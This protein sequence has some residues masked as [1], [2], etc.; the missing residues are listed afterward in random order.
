MRAVVSRGGRPDLAPRSL[1]LVAAPTL[2]IVGEL[3][4]DVLASNRA[5][6]EELRCEKRIAIVPGASH[7]FEEPG[8][9]DEA[10]RLA[11]EWFARLL[12]RDSTQGGEHFP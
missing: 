10:C 8:C 12:P 2:L 4:T 7:L 9:L 1:P 5:A 3:D 11:S 6:A